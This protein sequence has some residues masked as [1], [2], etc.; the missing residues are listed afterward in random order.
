MNKEQEIRKSLHFDLLLSLLRHM[1]N[2]DYDECQDIFVFLKQLG[3]ARSGSEELLRLAIDDDYIYA[4][5]ASTTQRYNI[6]QPRLT[7]KALRTLALWPNDHDATREL[8]EQMI[9]ALE[10]IASTK[11]PDKSKALRFAAN[12]IREVMVQVTAEIASKTLIG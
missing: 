11:A 6:L 9:A 12:T 2:P 10:A 4:I 3:L 5:E 8:V 7:P 1:A